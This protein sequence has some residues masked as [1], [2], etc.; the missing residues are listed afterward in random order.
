MRIKAR[1]NV[2]HAVRGV[3]ERLM[4]LTTK[5]RRCKAATLK[6]PLYPI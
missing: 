1:E 5:E 4:P 3:Q 6:E 2:L